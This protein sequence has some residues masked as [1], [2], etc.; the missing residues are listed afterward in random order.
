[1][2]KYNLQHFAQVIDAQ[3]KILE[4]KKKSNKKVVGVSKPPAP[5]QQNLLSPVAT[6]ALDPVGTGNNQMP[7]FLRPNPNYESAEERV[8]NRQSEREQLENA[9]IKQQET[10]V[11]EPSQ[12]QQAPRIDNTDLIK[13]QSKA[14][15]DALV[16][17]LKQRIEE[18]KAKQQGIIAK[19]PQRFD[20]L[21]ASSEV[22]KSQQLRSALERSSLLGD[23]GG[24][25]RSEALLTQTSGENRLN[26]IN[27]QQQNLI[28]DANAEIARLENEGR[29]QEAQIIAAQRSQELQNLLAEQQRQQLFDREDASIARQDALRNEALQLD[30]QD[31]ERQ[32]FISA[33]GR[34]S[35]DFTA[36]INRVSNDGDPTNDWQIPLLETAKQEKIQSQG[37]D[38]FGNPLPVDNTAQIEDSAYRKINAGIPLNAQ[39]AQVLGVREGYTKPR[40]TSGG[41]SG[42]LSASGLSTNARFKL[43]NGIPLSPQEAQVLGLPA[44]YVSPSSETTE[45]FLREADRIV[46]PVTIDS[47]SDNKKSVL[48]KIVNSPQ[49]Y[50]SNPDRLRAILE[51][52]NISIEELEE[53]ENWRNRALQSQAFQKGV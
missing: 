35:Q 38:Q 4:D 23:R 7:D 16:A 50:E 40:T 29:F 34:F 27:L 48:E 15:T 3:G 39:E 41:S 47:I 17:Q 52:Q 37:L 24:V 30:T 44:G 33:L 6:P 11:S 42:G 8:A 28:A 2:I 51:D 45:E 43:T 31:R 14:N 32:Q 22:A 12:T 13:Q 18:S 49:L 25:G 5:V 19:A 21:R 10:S 53:Y 26:A 9:L 1:M 20:P 46:N 36:E